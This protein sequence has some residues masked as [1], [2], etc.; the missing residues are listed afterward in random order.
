MANAK[1]DGYRLTYGGL[2]YLALHQHQRRSAIYSVGNQIGVGKESDIYVVAGPSGTQHVLKIH[3]LGRI[4]FRTVK[5]KRDYLKSSRHPHNQG[6]GWQYMSKLAAIKEHAFMKVL[7]EAGFPVPEPLAQ[8]RHTIVMQLIDAFPMRQV[9]EVADPAGLYAEL[10]AL[11]LRFASVGLIHGDF[12]EF[13]VLLRED[14]TPGAPTVLTPIVIDFPQTLS[15]DHPNAE[16]YFDRDVACVKRY[17]KRR[18]K[19]TPTESGPTFEDARRQLEKASGPAAESQRRRRLDVEVAAT[20]FSKK[21]AKELERYMVEVGVDGD[22][23]KLE[24]GEA[25]VT[26]RS[27]ADDD[28]GE[29]EHGEGVVEDGNDDGRIQSEE[30]RQ[31]R[32]IEAV[33][34]FTEE[35][36]EDDERMMRDKL[37][38]WVRRPTTAEV[39]GDITGG[40]TDAGVC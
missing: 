25:D 1:Y 2:D 27:D 37:G 20:G 33:E 40:K 15:V 18:Y 16:M 8:T 9:A 29:F 32:E 4:S 12:N 5:A 31:R 30:S 7:W 34:D 19:F 23:P 39:G 28:D 13:N 21:M 36:E 38:N 10:I 22:G 17:F 11:I 6:A 26:A 24:D 14:K 35:F 3:R